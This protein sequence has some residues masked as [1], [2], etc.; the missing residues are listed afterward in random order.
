MR[1]AHESRR[2]RGSRLGLLLGVAWVL[3][4]SGCKKDEAA[5]TEEPVV[6]L[7]QE[8][9]ARAEVS[10]LQ[11]GPGIS[12]TLQARS[13]AAVRSEV[14]G[15]I[16]EIKAEQGQRVRKGQELARIEDTTLRDQ[17]I[18]ART[19]ARTA[20]SALQVAKSEEERN[21]KLAKA[22]VITQ[23]DYERIQLSV[24]QAEGQ[25][26]EAHSR[27]ALSREQVGRARVTAPFDGV[28]SERQASAGDVVQPGAPLFT[29]VDPRTL[30]LEASVPAA[31]LEQVKAGTPVEF[32]V[33]GYGDRTF[34]GK[35]ERINP[36][37]DPGTGQVRI[38][39]TIPNTDL[40][41]LAGLFAEGRVASEARRALS[42][43]VDAIDEANHATAVLRVQDER[44]HRVPVTLG[45]RDDV[46]QRV[47]VRSGLKAGDVVLL[48]SARDEVGEGARVKVQA[49]RPEQQP[50]AEEGPG[51][52]G[53]EAPPR[54]QSPAAQ[55]GQG[56]QPSTQPGQQGGA[57]GASS[58]A[59]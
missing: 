46:A 10:A 28:V 16:L 33:T 40:E 48:G 37:V 6:T 11:S 1:R 41:L 35:V 38:Y 31:K 53:S 21:S 59:H 44:V 51:V 20:E 56:Q 52:G 14:G 12:G 27:L 22:G 15:T 36:V 30:R 2:T 57:G 18:A 50:V 43:P 47:E 24:S 5:P 13:A 8:N 49:P 54:P 34:S 9:V 26:A 55:Q 25:L 29:V 32:E 39:V 7:G 17:L 4:T 23:R 19:A 3:S 45:L 58:P 42:V